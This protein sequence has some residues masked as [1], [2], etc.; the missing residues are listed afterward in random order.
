M[1]LHHSQ[2]QAT[3]TDMHA[4]SKLTIALDKKVLMKVSQ[5]FRKEYA[6]VFLQRK[7]DSDQA[8]IA[9]LL[10]LR[11]PTRRS[12]RRISITISLSDNEEQQMNKRTKKLH[13]HPSKAAKS[14]GMNLTNFRISLFIL[15]E[16]LFYT[17]CSVPNELDGMQLPD[18]VSGGSTP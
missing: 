18:T 9:A 4:L 11:K 1:V 13:D 10:N 12:G 5:S 6:M 16:C 14:K 7:E 15:L 17:L 2:T 3:E 8:F